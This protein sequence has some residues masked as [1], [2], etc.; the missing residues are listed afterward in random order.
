MGIK[1]VQRSTF[2]W[3]SA[4]RLGRK[5]LQEPSPYV[6]A[7][8]TTRDTRLSPSPRAWAVWLTS[9]SLRGVGPPRPQY[10]PENWFELA[11]CYGIFAAPPHMLMCGVR[12]RIGLNLPPVWIRALKYSTAT[13]C[14]SRNS[15]APL[16]MA[17]FHLGPPIRNTR[18]I[19]THPTVNSN[20]D[21]NIRRVRQKREGFI[22]ASICNFFTQR[23]TYR[24]DCILGG[25]TL[26]QTLSVGT[27]LCMSLIQPDRAYLPTSATPS[28]PILPPRNREIPSAP[29]KNLSNIYPQGYTHYYILRNLPKESAN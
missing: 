22:L 13:D 20:D 19:T 9:G 4:L 16:I 28:I 15:D 17:V 23:F 11:E 24:Y 10:P 18:V 21:S 7:F 6:R 29:N 12:D 27:Q 1:N 3:P 2:R 8:F 25:Y 5:G 14:R 26:L